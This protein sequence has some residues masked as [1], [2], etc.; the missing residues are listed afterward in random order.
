MSALRS[1]ES[2]RIRPSRVAATSMS[3]IWSRPWI[4][5]WK[6]SLRDSVHFTGRPSLRATTSAMT[7]SAYTLSFEPK[8]PPTSGAMTRICCSGMPHVS[9]SISR[10]MCGIW[11]AE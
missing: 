10:R 6:P 2:P 11:V 4:V 9:A 5:A 3:W 7:S 8:P 1:T